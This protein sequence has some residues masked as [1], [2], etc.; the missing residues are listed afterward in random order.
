MDWSQE[1]N[2]DDSFQYE[3]NQL[4]NNLTNTNQQ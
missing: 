4:E 1:Q 2:M 3:E